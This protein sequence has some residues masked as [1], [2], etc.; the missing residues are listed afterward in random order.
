MSAPETQDTAPTVSLKDLLSDDAERR[1]SAGT[2]AIGQLGADD[3]TAT[4]KRIATLLPDLHVIDAKINTGGIGHGYF[5]SNPAVSSDLILILRD[6]LNPGARN[7]RP[8]SNH[9]ANFWELHEDY[10]NFNSSQ[11]IHERN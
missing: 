7:G 10:P 3:L 1:G 4:Q 5:H 8:L 9:V 11:Q 6:N 2:T